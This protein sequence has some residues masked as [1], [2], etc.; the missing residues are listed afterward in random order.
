MAD[1]NLSGGLSIPGSAQ[2]RKKAFSV[3]LRE[4]DFDISEVPCLEEE[5]ISLD[6]DRNLTPV[7]DK[8][9]S[10]GQTLPCKASNERDVSQSRTPI[11]NNCSPNNHSLIKNSRTELQPHTTSQLVYI[12]LTVIYLFCRNLISYLFH[13]L[14][15]ESCTSSGENHLSLGN[16]YNFFHYIFQSTTDNQ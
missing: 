1:S 6:N 16:I 14:D 10:C 11:I 13:S 5:I 7:A 9:Y 3:S 15:Y 4:N 12:Y 8:C 2:R